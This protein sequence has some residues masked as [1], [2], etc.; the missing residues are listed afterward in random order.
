M[1]EAHQT[2]L[3]HVFIIVVE[4]AFV[5]ETLTVHIVAITKLGGL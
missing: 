3:I 5:E 4:E 2:V 1:G